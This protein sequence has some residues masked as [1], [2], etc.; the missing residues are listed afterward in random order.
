MLSSNLTHSNQPTQITMTIFEHF[1]EHHNEA[2][3]YYLNSDDEEPY[4]TIDEV[5]AENYREEVAVKIQSLA[6]GV[7]T[8]RHIHVALL[9]S[10]PD[11]LAKAI[12]LCC[13]KRFNY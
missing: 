3:V 8:R 4:M 11:E 1:M 6:R 5:H 2:F 13:R 9:S 10:D 7:L 12:Q